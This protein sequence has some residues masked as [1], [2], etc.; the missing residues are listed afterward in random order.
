MYEMLTA[1]LERTLCLV[2]FLFASFKKFYVFTE[3]RTQDF[4]FGKEPESDKLKQP[5]KETL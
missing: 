2:Y 1:L 4:Q 5:D 3:I